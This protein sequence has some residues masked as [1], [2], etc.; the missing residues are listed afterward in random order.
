MNGIWLKIADMTKTNLQKLSDNN[1]LNLFLE[2][3][4]WNTN[5]TIQSWLS[6]NQVANLKNLANS[7]NP[8]FKLYAWIYWS[9]A[10]GANPTDLS[11]A[12]ARQA[13]VNGAAVFMNAYA[14]DGLNDDLYEGF[15]GSDQNYIDFINAVKTALPNKLVSTD[16]FAWWSSDI[17]GHITKIYGS[18]T[19]DYLCPMLYDS[20][21]WSP[22]DLCSRATLIL[23]A[24][25]SPVLLGVMVNNTGD[26]SPVQLKDVLAALD[27]Q[28]I[29][30]HRNFGGIALW[31]FDMFNQAG[32]QDW[33]AWSAWVKNHSNG[34][35]GESPMANITF[36]G[37]VSGQEK[38]QAGTIKVTLPNGST[39]TITITTG[40]D[41]KFT[42]TKQYSAAGTYKAKASFTA[43]A[44]YKACESEEKTFTITAEL[45][46]RT[47]TLNVSVA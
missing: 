17:P 10:G 18:I 12:S 3:G 36:S 23:N 20:Q 6:Q 7:V 47:V 38:P 43:D 15:N 40:A 35:G 45:L 44:Q 1:I 21:G 14:F 34:G 29:P 11:T 27:A 8:A 5:G 39:E 26:S 25:K 37:E 13:A 22:S 16:L 32:R 4:Y 42:A 28:N 9:A 30:A 19:A 41:R 33:A 24:A 31:E 46:D 2:T